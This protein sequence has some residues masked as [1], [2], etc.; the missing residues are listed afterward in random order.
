[1]N[2]RPGANAPLFNTV[3]PEQEKRKA[4]VAPEPQPQTQPSGAVDPKKAIAASSI[5][6]PSPTAAPTV[7]PI[8]LTSSPTVRPKPQTDPP[9]QGDV[10]L[11]KVGGGA[12]DFFWKLPQMTTTPDVDWDGRSLTGTLAECMKD[13]SDNHRCWGFYRDGVDDNVAALCRHRK[14]GL[15]DRQDNIACVP[16]LPSGAGY[17]K[18]RAEVKRG[19]NLG[20]IDN[21]YRPA[22]RGLPV[23]VVQPGPIR[24]A[25]W[26]TPKYLNY[27]APVASQQGAAMGRVKAHL[28]AHPPNAK[29][30]PKMMHIIWLGTQSPPAFVNTWTKDFA[31]AFPAW[32][33]IVWRD[34]DLAPIGMLNKACFTKAQDMREKSDIARLEILAIAGGVY[35]DADAIWMGNGLDVVLESTRKTGFFSSFEPMVGP[36]TTRGF[37]DSDELKVFQKWAGEKAQAVIQNGFLGAAPGHA[38]VRKALELIGGRCGKEKPWVTTG[39]Y[40]ISSVVAQFQGEGMP[41]SNL[42]TIVPHAALFANFWHIPEGHKAMSPPTMDSLYQLVHRCSY[43]PAVSFQVGLGTNDRKANYDVGRA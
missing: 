9:S 19:D 24:A 11:E 31:V 38:V 17:Y 22:W 40:L 27:E 42:V 20:S 5:V 15:H 21:V 1:M 26:T 10:I 43:H 29:V 39:P 32:D 23:T 33:V 4:I 18:V 7:P 35:M 25:R 12:F 13:C 34:D 36:D 6:S 41:I 8:A 2:P 16:L 28:T 37:T 3:I 14:F 30:I